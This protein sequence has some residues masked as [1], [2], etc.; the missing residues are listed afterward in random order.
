MPSIDSLG[1]M[2]LARKNK[3]WGKMSKC[4]I[5]VSGCPVEFDT[6]FDGPGVYSSGV[7]T[8]FSW[9]EC[10]RDCRTKGNKYFSWAGTVNGNVQNQCHCRESYT[11]ID[12]NYRNITSGQASGCG[13]ETFKAKVVE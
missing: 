5:F 9:E 12:Y 11:S 6:N 2:A 10:Q 8:S 4:W 13:G 1:A 3:Y 7:N